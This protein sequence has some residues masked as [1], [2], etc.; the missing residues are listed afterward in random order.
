VGGSLAGAPV[1]FHHAQYGGISGDIFVYIR[2]TSRAMLVWNVDAIAYYVISLA[3]RFVQ[4]T[5]TDSF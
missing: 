1:S 3:A 2:D 4:G 5:S